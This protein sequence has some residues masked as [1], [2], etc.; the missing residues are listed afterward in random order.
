[1]VVFDLANQAGGVAVAGGERITAAREEDC[2][3]ADSKG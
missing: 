1:V 2:V 3:G